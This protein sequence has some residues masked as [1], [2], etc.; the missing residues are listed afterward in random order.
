MDD[1]RQLGSG[2]LTDHGSD[3]R[4]ASP[5]GYMKPTSGRARNP[6]G[7]LS[8]LVHL[9]FCSAGKVSSQRGWITDEVARNR[10]GVA[11][12]LGAA[13]GFKKELLLQED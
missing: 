1:A 3:F 4:R 2:A 8:L 6:T 11:G 10:T 12:C 7:L 13:N 9:L 5:V